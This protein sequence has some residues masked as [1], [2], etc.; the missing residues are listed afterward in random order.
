MPH[1]PGDSSSLLSRSS[2][3]EKVNMK[4]AWQHEFPVVWI[5]D[6]QAR[7]VGE[8]HRGGVATRL[9]PQGNSFRYWSHVILRA[10]RNLLDLLV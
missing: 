1:S 4:T 10:R 8:S 9:G 6:N 5:L 3:E 7:T 2:Q